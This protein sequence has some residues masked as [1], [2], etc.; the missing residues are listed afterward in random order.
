[1]STSSQRHTSEAIISSCATLNRKL[2]TMNESFDSN[3]R[4]LLSNKNNLVAVMDNNQKGNNIKH[5]K[6]GHSNKFVKVTRR[7]FNNA[8]YSNMQRTFQ[9]Y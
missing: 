8:V 7:F 6:N 9:F 2:T 4:K 3:F 1:M 5:Q